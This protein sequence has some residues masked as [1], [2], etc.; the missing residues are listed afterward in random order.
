MLSLGVW[1]V[2]ADVRGAM[3]LLERLAAHYR[4]AKAGGRPVEG[5]P[6]TAD[7]GLFGSPE[8]LLGRLVER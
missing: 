2:L 5:Q 1:H 7:C 4:G 3:L 6:L 8:E